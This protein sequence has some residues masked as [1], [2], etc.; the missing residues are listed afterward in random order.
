MKAKNC[1]RRQRRATDSEGEQR[2]AMES[3]R[4]LKT[5]PIES[6]MIYFISMSVMRKSHTL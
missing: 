2:R 6:N 5:Y 3:G 4:G 1:E